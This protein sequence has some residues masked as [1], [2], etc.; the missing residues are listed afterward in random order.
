VI[1]MVSEAAQ[2]VHVRAVAAELDRRG[3]RYEIYDPAWYPQSSAVSAESSGAGVRWQLSWGSTH[4]AMSDVTAIWY[5]RPGDFGL[6]ADLQPFERDWL[7]VECD[8]VFSALWESA[9]ALWVSRPSA[10]RRA[11]LKLLQ[12]DLARSIGFAVPGFAL[13]NDV[14]VARDFIA[15]CRDGTVV[16]V[17]SNP[18]IL[19]G[20]R[21]GAIYT[22]L[23]NPQDLDVLDSVRHGPTFLQEYVPKRRDIR[24]TVMGK[25]VIAVAIDSPILDR[26]RVDFRRAEI[27]DLPHEV[28]ALPPD[29]SRACVQLVERLGLAFGAIDLVQTADGGFLF[30]E[31]NPN[32]QWYWLEEIT[33]APL[34]ATMCDLLMSSRGVSS[35]S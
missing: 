29:L 17:L 4:L 3:E 18:A 6:S 12:L 28:I 19:D 35:P 30:L 13:T 27:Y 24:V 21:A 14:D 20:E 10:I 8:H 7:R 5:R 26:S 34:A 9:S 32:G 16:K 23:L 1:L 11:G 25:S 22:H 31:I 2:D 15:S 33:A